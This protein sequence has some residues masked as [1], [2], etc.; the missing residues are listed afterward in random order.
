MVQVKLWHVDMDA[1]GNR[2]GSTAAEMQD[3]V[4]RNQHDMATVPHRVPM[5]AV[6]RRILSPAR[7]SGELQCNPS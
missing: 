7:N 6:L 2:L 1:A 4:A 3:V 5:A